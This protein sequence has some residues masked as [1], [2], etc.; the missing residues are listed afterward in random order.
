M[1]FGM[2]VVEEGSSDLVEESD[3]IL[4]HNLLIK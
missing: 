3:K 1:G 2:T 4:S